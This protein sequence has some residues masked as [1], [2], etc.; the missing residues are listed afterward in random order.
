MALMEKMAQME[1]TALQVKT[2]K[3]ERLALKDQLDRRA[4]KAP[5]AHKVLQEKM[6]RTVAMVLTEKM[7]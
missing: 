4:H 5:L 2:E 7:V 1:K 6:A 3:M